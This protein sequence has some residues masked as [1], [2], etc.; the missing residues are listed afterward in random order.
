ME[1]RILGPLEVV[2]DGRAV[3]LDRRR[4]RA[5]LAFLL[6]HANELVSSDRLIDEVWG[7]D[8]PKTAGAS[9]QNYVSR[10]RKA[11]GTEAIVS[12]PPG[13]VLRIDPER[14]DLARFERLTTE[15][16]GA[17]PRERA[18]KLRAALALW[19][20]PALDDLA[21]EP[22][23]RDEVGRLEEARLAAL[24]DCIDAE[25]EIGRDGELV[26]ELEE[27]VEE[28][29]LRER[30]R[31][32]LM[33]ALYRAGRQADALAAFQSA[34]DVLVEELGLEPGEELRQLQQAILQQDE[35]LGAAAQSTAE[36]VPD[37]RTVTVL[38]C[39]L[40]GSSELAARL[41]PEAYRALLSRYFEL[42][43]QPIE[44][45]GGTLEKFIGDAVMAVFGVPDLHED[46]ALRGVRAA[47][48]AQS[49]LRG[50]EIAARIGVSTGEVH[51]LSAPGEPLHVSGPPASVAS[52]LEGRAPTGSVLL[53]EDTYALVRDALRAEPFEDAWLVEEVVPGAPA[54]A[55]RLDAPLVG[56]VEELERLHATYVDAR[57]SRHCRVVTVVGE[58]GIG[59][60]RLMRELLLT[61]REEARVLVGRCVSYGEGAT[62]LPIAE[63]VR[64]AVRDT[65]LEGITALLAGEED[66]DQV[67]RRVGELIGIA[68]TPAA[69]GEA[70]W[71][72]RRFVEA[73]ARE[74]PVAL[75]LDDI[76]WAEPTLLD[77]IEYLGEWAEG[78]VLVLCAARREL[79]ESRHAWGGPTSTGFLVELSPLEADEVEQ[80][81]LGLAHEPVDPD[82]ERRIVEHAGGNPLF[83]E[84]LLALATEAPDFALAETPP[85]VEALLASRLDR[86][87]PRELAVLRRAS[88]V[89]RRF[90]RAELADLTP[91]EEAGRTGQHL[92]EL[93]RRALVHPREH[94]FAFHHVLVRDVAYRGIPKAERA[95]L[96]ELAARGL[97]RREGADEIV[98]FHFEQGYRYLTEI[99]GDADRAQALA[100]AGGERLGLAGVRAWKRADVQAAVALLSRAL[101]L[102]PTTDELACE[103]GLALRAAGN[104]DAARRRLE[105]AAHAT[106]E[107]VA[108]RGRLEL[109]FQR[110]TVEPD[111]AAELL[112]VATTALPIFER[113]DRALGRAWLSIAHVRGGFYCE[114]AA[115]E[116]AASRAA[117][118]YRRSG[119]SSS[120]ALDYLGLAL[121]FGPRPVGEA[122]ARCEELL[123]TYEGD[124]ASEANIRVWLAPLEALRGDFDRARDDVARAKLIYQDLGL[125]AAVV[126]TCGRTL[127]WIEMLGGAPDTAA[128]LLREC[129]AVLETHNQTA[130]LATRAAELGTAL[131]EQGRYDDAAH[132]VGVARAAAGTDDLDAVLWRQPLEARLLARDGEPAAAERLARETVDLVARTDALNRHADA[133]VVFAEILQAVDREQEAQDRLR[134]A[135]T[136]YERKENKVAADRLRPRLRK[137]TLAR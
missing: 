103:L 123:D 45:H 82:V 43:R 60:T 137:A 2:K 89:G 38:F 72:V 97:D 84:Q 100:T 94:V 33:R 79:L 1:F 20:G 18:E 53:S 96:H 35:S 75:V 127:A 122:I 30:F 41:D 108:L 92:T 8:P 61:L 111:R 13:Y 129:C 54:Y 73:I 36:R 23:A 119:W 44:R 39:D 12:Q 62:Y 90:T 5:L 86:L 134:E 11:I 83:V 71:A 109:A 76:H 31:A 93:T 22:F 116:D 59:K 98:G 24:E 51:V 77:L 70:F 110:S 17:E 95:E 105:E 37:R 136:L 107:Q 48:D 104:F 80:L 113:N 106:D 118:C 40:V 42:V 26:R 10:L 6:L 131:F 14:F 4:L 99:G 29:P 49:A 117:A 87:A 19:R 114:Y 58:A 27:L 16:R 67:A 65:S 124:R 55:R 7:P 34:R 9:L 28:H 135:L 88:V 64:Q 112:D 25:L 68:E 102:K 85:T 32:Q 21:F 125:A 52:R 81:L 91:P 46:D 57:D 3:P 126:D 74:R 101:E 128:A 121:Y 50:A 133:L 63:M 47:V 132:W 66:A 69:P 115:M 56:R 15:A 120:S 130:V 78:R